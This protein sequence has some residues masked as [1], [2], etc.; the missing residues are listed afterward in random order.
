M[1]DNTASMLDDKNLNEDQKEELKRTMSSDQTG[2]FPA[3][4]A[5]GHT[6]LLVMRDF[7]SDFIGD[8]PIKDHSDD[9]LL[10]KDR[11]ELL[12]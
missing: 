11:L 6:P 8:E 1:T 5:R 9:E 12:K 4:S 2:R 10:R 7:D 3:T